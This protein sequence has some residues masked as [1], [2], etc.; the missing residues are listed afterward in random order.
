MDIATIIFVGGLCFVAFVLTMTFRREFRAKERQRRE[1]Q[2]Q[3][4]HP[5]PRRKP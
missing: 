2:R 5:R 3:S 4:Q 1:D